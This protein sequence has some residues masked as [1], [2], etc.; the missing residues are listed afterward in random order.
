MATEQDNSSFKSF[1]SPD[2]SSR[3]EEGIE[4]GDHHGEWYR[5]VRLVTAPNEQVFIFWNATLHSVSFPAATLADLSLCY[6]GRELKTRIDLAARTFVFHPHDEP[7]PLT[8]F[9]TS[10]LKLYGPAAVHRTSARSRFGDLLAALAS[11]AFVAGGVYRLLSQ[12]PFSAD[13]WKAVA[14][15]A[16]FGLCAVVM[17][18]SLF[19]TR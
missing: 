2:G 13:W 14:A 5:V 9:H 19:K 17:L 7:E 18:V 1:S 6:F 3:I 8:S 15:T 16:F 4:D 11:C 12:S 10:F